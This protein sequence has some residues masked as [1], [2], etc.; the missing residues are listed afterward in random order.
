MSLKTL[1]TCLYPVCKSMYSVCVRECVYCPVSLIMLHVQRPR[2]QPARAAVGQI[3]NKLYAKATAPLMPGLRPSPGRQIYGMAL[4]CVGLLLCLQENE[5]TGFVWK[6]GWLLP[7]ASLN[8]YLHVDSFL[9]GERA[10]M[11]VVRPRYQGP[12]R[13]L[14]RKFVFVW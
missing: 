12:R 11:A 9:K 6:F 2:A 4:D 5:V 14:L 3:Q 10:R 8:S 13:V 1:A 7:C